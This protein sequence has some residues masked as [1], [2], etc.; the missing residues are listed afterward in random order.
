[1]AE[2]IR[3]PCG[4]ASE[5]RRLIG[6]GKYIASVEY[7]DEAESYYFNVASL[8]GVGDV[9][10]NPLP[11][12]YRSG[13]RGRNLGGVS[14]YVYG[15]GA[16]NPMALAG[17]DWFSRF[18]PVVSAASGGESTTGFSDSS[19]GDG[20]GGDGPPA[21]PTPPAPP[22]S[23]SPA[24]DNLVA[25]LLNAINTD[26]ERSKAAKDYLDHLKWRENWRIMPEAVLLDGLR[27]KSIPDGELAIE[28]ICSKIGTP[29]GEHRKLLA[30]VV[31]TAKEVQ[32]QTTT[33]GRL[34]WPAFALLV[35]GLGASG[36][37][38]YRGF[39]QVADGK[40]HGYELIIMIFVLALVAVSPAV[41]LLLQRP[42]KGLDQWS[43]PS[44][45]SPDDESGSGKS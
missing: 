28:I 25:T 45:K 40:L 33:W 15:L 24:D 4:D 22:S 35:A 23:S 42:L 7:D 30:E 31:A 19:S 10:V 13:M 2:P 8:D 38:T 26:D 14:P 18:V 20:S 37:F 44:M 39:Q 41:L 27:D 11:L 6:E 5:V 36:Y 32:N 12:I 1:M 16:D 17:P 3:V 9:L 34:A 43:P 21:P 29:S